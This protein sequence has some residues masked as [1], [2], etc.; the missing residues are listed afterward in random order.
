VLLLKRL[1]VREKETLPLKPLKDQQ[2]QDEENER[3][4]VVRREKAEPREKAALREEPE[5]RE[6]AALRRKKAALREKLLREKAAL[7]SEKEEDKQY[8][9]LIS[10]FLFF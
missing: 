1:H 8:L 7:R 10:P 3:Q 6:K 9:Q 5:P 4:L 2:L